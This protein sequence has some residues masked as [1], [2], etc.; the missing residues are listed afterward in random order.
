MFSY[1]G[2]FCED[3]NERREELYKFHYFHCMC[4]ACDVSDEEVKKQTEICNQYKDLEIGWHSVDLRI[5][6]NIFKEMYNLAKSMKTM[7]RITIL[8]GPLEFGFAA[9]CKGAMV[10]KS[11]GKPQLTQEFLKDAASFT[12]AGI[13]ISEW[14]YGELHSIAKDWVRRNKDPIKAFKETQFLPGR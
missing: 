10:S 11:I 4:E 3:R 7:K 8:H 14:L 5:Q 9:A 13:V 12:K 2:A 6:V 1:I